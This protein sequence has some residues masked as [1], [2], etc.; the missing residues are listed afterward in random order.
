MTGK[1]FP[2]TKRFWNK[3]SKTSGCWLWMAGT[4]KKGYGRIQLQNSK[5]K[6][7]A[8]RLSWE[9]EYGPIPEGLKVLH[10]CDNPSCV[11]PKHLFLGT[12][13]D[14]AID[15]DSKGRGNWDNADHGENHHCAKLTYKKVSEIKQLLSQNERGKDIAMQFGV[16]KN[17]ISKI[18]L[19]LTWKN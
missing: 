14:N 19:G 6:I 18:K 11:N 16:S 12:D 3:V 17:T 7:L 5:R 15:R 8:H 13:K 9:L 1:R 2:L 10:K 4:N